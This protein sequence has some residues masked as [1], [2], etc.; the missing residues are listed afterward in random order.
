LYYKEVKD[1][2]RGVGQM[3][4]AIVGQMLQRTISPDLSVWDQATVWASRET[5]EEIILVS[6]TF[7]LVGLF[8][9]ALCQSL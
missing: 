6:T 8:F 5:I 4:K 9:F 7:P 2:Q 1:M 3:F